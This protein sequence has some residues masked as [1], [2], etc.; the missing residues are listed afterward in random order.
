MTFDNAAWVINGPTISAALARRALYANAR[1]SGIVQK[2]DL[3]VKA[4]DTPGIGITIDEGVGVVLNGYQGAD[5]NEAYVVNN[6]G[7]HTIPSGSMPASNPSQTYW[8]VCAVVG[9]EDFSQ[10]G[11]P[12]MTSEGVPDGTEDSFAYVRPVL[13]QCNAGDTQPTGNFPA[14][15]LARLEIPA[16]TTTITQAMIVDLRKLA[17]PRQEQQ[18]FVSPGGTWTNAS[19]R[20]IPHG[21]VFADWGPQE[22]KPSVNV[23]SWASRA[24]VAASINGI[25]YKD[26]SVNLAGKV[27]A[28]L[29]TVSGPQTNFDLEVDAGGGV[30]RMSLMA[31]GEYDVTSIAGTTVFLRIEGYQNA[32]AA[33]T[34]DQ[35]L[36]LQGGS[37]VVF[38]VRFFE[39]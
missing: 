13:I 1:Q 5:P 10:V 38:D 14:L 17:S 26:T 2:G 4:L 31:A 9:D 37:Q 11:H 21:T 29:G 20:E 27:R 35:T 15:V 8:L 16:N 18:M 6:P 22:Y 33:P 34:N 23:P 36:R 39:E 30:K 32:P 25:R 19:P 24:I 12:F 3:K 28:Q 7:V